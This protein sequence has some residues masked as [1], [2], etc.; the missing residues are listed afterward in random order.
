[1][2][3]ILVATFGDHL[4]ATFGS[5]VKSSIAEW[6]Q[7]GAGPPFVAEDRDLDPWSWSPL[8]V[9][10]E[11]YLLPIIFS[12]EG[13]NITSVGVVSRHVRKTHASLVQD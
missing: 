5:F 12:Y 3:G 9:L 4:T 2:E 10:G 13:N 6:R 11:L 7:E 1:M 8:P